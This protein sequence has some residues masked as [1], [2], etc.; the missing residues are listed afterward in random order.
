[1]INK[2][3]RDAQGP[4]V[5]AKRPKK[6][7]QLKKPT[8]GKATSSKV[9]GSQVDVDPDKDDEATA[10]APP[11][12]SANR[13]K[14]RGRKQTSRSTAA[15]TRKLVKR[16]AG[17]KTEASK[18]CPTAVAELR[19]SASHTSAQAAGCSSTVLEALYALA[20]PFLVGEDDGGTRLSPAEETPKRPAWPVHPAQTGATQRRPNRCAKTAGDCSLHSSASAGASRP[21]SSPR[22]ASI[23]RLRNGTAVTFADDAGGAC[24]HKV[25]VELTELSLAA[26]L[27]LCGLSDAGVEVDWPHGLDYVTALE[28]LDANNALDFDAPWNGSVARTAQ[29][30]PMAPSTLPEAQGRDQ[31]WGSQCL[32]DLVDLHE[33]GLP[34]RWPDGLDVLVARELLLR[35]RSSSQQAPAASSA[36]GSR[37]GS[38]RRASAS[39]SSCLHL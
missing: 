32:L 33:S 7:E 11:A 17:T 5:K 39:S 3:K 37:S 1:M 16:L 2:T 25:E 35:R 10:A 24:A 14:H 6:L 22:V 20:K 8:A 15:T 12:P 31:E 27:K 38:S 23:A 13:R 19:A 26:L 34:V 30:G 29:A 36:E 21:E 9:N 28:L 4:P 18:P